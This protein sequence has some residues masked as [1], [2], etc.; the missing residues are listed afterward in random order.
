MKVVVCH[1]CDSHCL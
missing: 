1:K